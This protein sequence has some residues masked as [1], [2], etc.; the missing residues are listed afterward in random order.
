MLTNALNEQPLAVKGKARCNV[1]G[2]DQRNN[3]IHA[4]VVDLTESY[5][6]GQK[7]ALLAANGEHGYMA[8][9]LRADRENYTAVYG[10]APLSEVANSERTFPTDWIS[11][12]GTDVTD[13]FVKYARPLIGDDWVSVPLIDG[14]QRLARLNTS[15]EMFADQKLDAYIPQ[16]DRE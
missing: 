1:S 13:D 14:R 2:T 8:S 12:D 10:K 6:V 7:A 16:A 4:S 5:Y 3:M 15:K 11:E 9:I